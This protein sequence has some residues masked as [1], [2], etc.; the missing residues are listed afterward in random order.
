MDTLKL[1]ACGYEY[2]RYLI[3]IRPVATAKGTACSYVLSESILFR[4][5]TLPLAKK[6]KWV[7]DIDISILVNNYVFSAAINLL[8]PEINFFG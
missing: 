1:I 4:L 2:Y 6:E 7:V 8:S 5:Q 3:Q